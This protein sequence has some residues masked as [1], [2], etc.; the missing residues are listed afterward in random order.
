MGTYSV[1]ASEITQD[2]YVVNAEGQ[3]LGRLASEI[4][5]VLKGKRKPT[6]ST[7]LDVGDH[8]IVVNAEKVMVTGR[9]RDNKIYFRHSLYPGGHTL[10]RFRDLQSA[11]PEEIVRLAVK[12]M[13]PKNRLGRAML[14]K[15][16]I[17][18]GPEHPHVAQAPRPLPLPGVA[19]GGD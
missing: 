5:S 2:W 16:K 13:M 11:K 1:R 12:G 9:K 4:A 18:A 7:H 14:K 15:L 19:T 17:Y 10:T 8:V 6:Y 3:I